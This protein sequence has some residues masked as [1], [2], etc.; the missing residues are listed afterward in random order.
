MFKTS[1]IGSF[2]GQLKNLH[3]LEHSG[4]RETVRGNKKRKLMFLLTGNKKRKLMFL[5][6]EDA[7]VG[8]IWLKSMI[9]IGIALI[10]V[11]LSIRVDLSC[12]EN[13]TRKPRQQLMP[14]QE[15]KDLNI[16]IDKIL[17]SHKKVFEKQ[18]R[19]NYERKMNELLTNLKKSKVEN[20]DNISHKEIVAMKRAIE[21][22]ETFENIHLSLMGVESDNKSV[23]EI[24]NYSEKILLSRGTLTHQQF[25]DLLENVKTYLT[26]DEKYKRTLQLLKSKSKRLD[27]L[28]ELFKEQMKDDNWDLF[29]W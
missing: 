7:G 26:R 1:V 11:T 2:K 16:K 13:N 19:N 12:E 25:L 15:A 17:A 20:G 9:Y 14:D 23:E 29:D 22:F 8:M 27:E 3:G 24:K 18:P 21:E 10:A 6:T 5:L 28:I 4:K